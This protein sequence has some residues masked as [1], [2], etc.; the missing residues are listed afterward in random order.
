MLDCGLCQHLNISNFKGRS[1]CLNPYRFG[2]PYQ[3]NIGACNN[4]NISHLAYAGYKHWRRYV[5][6]YFEEAGQLNTL[7]VTILGGSGGMLCM[8]SETVFLAL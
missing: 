2:I 7:R 3:R 4:R 6:F 1:A 8:V 5:G